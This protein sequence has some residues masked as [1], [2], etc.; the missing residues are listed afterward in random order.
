MKKGSGA[1]RTNGTLQDVKLTR[2]DALLLFGG[3]AISAALTG[4]GSG[5]SP[6][7]VGTLTP[8]PVADASRTAISGDLAAQY[9][10]FSTIAQ[11]T[12]DTW[13][14]TSGALDAL[15]NLPNR[16]SRA[17][18]DARVVIQA[19]T[20][21]LNG[22]RS[23][24]ERLCN[25]ALHLDDLGAAAAAVTSN[26]GLTGSNAL[27]NEQWLTAMIAQNYAAVSV[28]G[29][30]FIIQLIAGLPEARAWALARTN[31]IDRLAAYGLVADTFNTWVDALTA[32]GNIT[33]NAA[34]KLDVSSAVTSA[35]ITAKLGQIDTILP[36]LPFSPGYRKPGASLSQVDDA[37]LGAVGIQNFAQSFTGA[38]ARLTLSTA[39]LTD[40][41]PQTV[42]TTKA[43]YDVTARLGTT[44][45]GQTIAALNGGLSA[46]QTVID[47]LLAS[48]DGTT[49]PG[50]TGDSAQCQVQI[51]V[52]TYGFLQALATAL[53]TTQSALG[54]LITG[55]QALQFLTDLENTMTTC[56]SAIQLALWNAVKADRDLLKSQQLYNGEVPTTR[57]VSVVRVTG[58]RE[59]DQI[60]AAGAICTNKLTISAPDVCPLNPKNPVISD[61][62]T[63]I[64]GLTKL[65]NC[66]R[67]FRNV[68]ICITGL[69]YE[70]AQ[71]YPDTVAAT[72]ETD[73][74]IK[75][76]SQTFARVLRREPEATF[77]EVPAITSAQLL[78]TGVGFIPSRSLTPVN[79]AIIP[80]MPRL[81]EISNLTGGVPI[82]VH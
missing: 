21:G 25:L 67:T 23:A 6:N 70:I 14:G 38:L 22:T 42:D 44:G 5:N 37:S 45:L 57:Q 26:N 32:A 63:I 43:H 58:L 73:S 18:S 50:V 28:T 13:L 74:S 66:P 47:G 64:G 76:C 55:S 20:I 36:Q 9:N 16:S 75:F 65:V 3:A 31:E 27:N 11:R 7:T 8:T 29:T 12:S 17:P 78:C 35:N 68:L 39:A 4:C 79:L 24:Y 61:Y 41:F 33:P 69:L 77:A 54:S 19:L 71:R 51:V 81:F 80:V 60:G 48:T 30:L 82:H 56:G 40:S 53:I 1:S 15:L 49:W 10:Q 52:K 34:W 59:L 72:W 46:A 2:R 62:R